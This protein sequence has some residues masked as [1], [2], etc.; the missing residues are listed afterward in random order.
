MAMFMMVAVMAG[1]VPAFAAT[2][3]SIG[4]TSVENAR[5]LGGYK[6]KDGRTVK[7]GKLIRTGELT[8]IT[9]KDKKTLVKK[10]KLVKNIDF[11]GNRDTITSPDPVLEGVEYCHYPFSS[12]KS[13]LLTE[14][15]LEN[16]VKYVQELLKGNRNG[17]FI[18]CGQRDRYGAMF[19]SKE[20]IAM[21]K[22][23][24][25]ELLDADGGAVLYHCVA[26]KDRTGNATLL[27]L[28]ALGVDKETIIQDYLLTNTFLK[29][30]IEDAYNLVYQLTHSKMIAED[31]TS[32]R[33]CHRDWIEESFNTLDTKYGSV[34]NYLRKEL[35]LSKAD[36]KALQNAYLQ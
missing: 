24:F 36:I 14:A 28:S 15:A 6:T 34:D 31:I 8:N 27:L 30:E 26:G 21:F 23:L 20:G 10:Y 18:Y 22:G 13:Y 17:K 4:L 19:T 29:D 33:S 7:Y 9:A 2:N 32:L 5:E 16:S 1:M 12:T 35:G 25:Q 11:R 3:H